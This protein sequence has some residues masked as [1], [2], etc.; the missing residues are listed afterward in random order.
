MSKSTG[1]FLRNAALIGVAY[2]LAGLAGQGVTMGL[3]LPAAPQAAAV[4]MGLTLVGLLL[5]GV[6]TGLVLGPVASRLTLPV[7]QRIGL[8]FI[9]LL[10]GNS[11]LSALE[12]VYFTTLPRAVLV[13]G[14]V[15]AAV[16]YAVTAWLLAW[17]Y[18]PATEDGDFGAALSAMLYRR[19]GLAWLWRLALSGILFVPVFAAFGSVVYPLVKQYYE[20]PALGLGVTVP[21]PNATLALELVRGLLF[22]LTLL[23]LLAFL[24]GP[25]WSQGLWLGLTLTVLVAVTPMLQTHWFPTP[26]RLLHG[27]EMTGDSLAHGMIIAWLLAVPQA[28]SP[29][30]TGGGASSKRIA[31]GKSKRRSHRA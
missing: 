24:P 31:T 10:A 8:L 14:I 28:A 23:P 15:G 7:G 1:V 25:R 21:D 26:M 13:S 2:A 5:S 11:L 27:L 29:G 4:S 9:V 30:V 22:T 3:G 6:V 16:T 18:P 12:A 20:N 17:L 19:S